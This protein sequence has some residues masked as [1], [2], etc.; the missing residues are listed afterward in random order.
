MEAIADTLDATKWSYGFPGQGWQRVGM[1]LELYNSSRAAR[2]VF[3]EANES[4]HFHLSR[5]MFQEPGMVLQDG[6]NLIRKPRFGPFTYLR[7]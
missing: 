7:I 1:G 4:L 6:I 5:L 3:E 2:A